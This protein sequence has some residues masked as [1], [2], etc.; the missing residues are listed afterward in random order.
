M[1]VARRE[2][3]ML[4]LA[5]L[6][7]P[8]VFTPD[9]FAN[10]FEKPNIYIE[11]GQFNWAKP[12][13]RKQ[14]SLIIIFGFGP[15]SYLL[16]WFFWP[17]LMG[18]CWTNDTQCWNSLPVRVMF[19]TSFEKPPNTRWDPLKSMIANRWTFFLKEDLRNLA[20]SGEWKR[21]VIKYAQVKDL[22]HDFT[23][24]KVA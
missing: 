14:T 21:L 19:A 17:S 12:W 9:L 10:G 4:C 23:T 6:G 7:A 13:S 24:W 20:F 22:Y 11:A 5:Q 1:G 2:S 3:L 8:K 16:S 18:W 15:R